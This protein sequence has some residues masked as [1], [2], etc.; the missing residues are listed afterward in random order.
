MKQSR[1][2]WPAI[3]ALLALPPLPAQTIDFARQVRPILSDKCYFCHGPAQQMKG[4]RFDR[5]ESAIRVVSKAA[6]ENE[7]L[8]RIT[9]QE[10]S[11]QMPPWRAVVSFTPAEVQILRTWVSL[12]AP[13]PEDTPPDPALE[14]LLRA[15]ARGDFASMKAEAR[16]RTV[17]NGHD[18]T[19]ATPLMHAAFEGN[20]ASMKLLL[21]AGADP[22]LANYTGSTALLW[23][24]D[25]LAKVRLLLAH[26]AK[27]DTRTSEGTTPLIAAA[28]F[29][30]CA[31]VLRALLD[32]GADPNAANRDGSTPLVQAA[33]IGDI[34]AMRFLIDRGARVNQEVTGQNPQVMGLSPLTVS[35][36]FGTTEMVQFLLERGAAVNAADGS[37]MTA[38]HIA[39]T[40]EDQKMIA[41]LIRAGAD[42]NRATLPSTPASDDPGT[43]LMLASNIE[44]ASASIVSTLLAYGARVDAVSR[45]GETAISRAQKRGQTAVVSALVAAGARPASGRRELATAPAGNPPTDVRAAVGKSLAL[46]RRA[47]QPFLQRAG[48][49]SC[50]NAALPALAIRMAAELGFSFDP[51]MARTNDAVTRSSI[52]SWFEKAVQMMDPDGGSP[53]STSFALINLDRPADTATNAIVRNIAARQLPDGRWRPP[54]IRHP[55]EEDATI[56]AISMRALQLYAPGGQRARYQMQIRKAA[57]WLS[58]FEPRTT[59]Q[60]TF[61]LLGLTWAKADAAQRRRRARELWTEQRPDGGWSQLNSLPSDAYATGEVL[62]AL[63]ESGMAGGHRFE[64]ERGVQFL[65]QTQ[66][67]D[68]SWHVVSRAVRF[69]QHFETGFPYGKDQFLSAAATSWAAMALMLSTR[70]RG[71]SGSH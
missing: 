9:S 41:A 53:T 30:G 3:S 31:P 2:F 66:Q 67:P 70:D 59:E 19:G 20:L 16:N 58:A 10:P 62:Y 60:R 37:G 44:P 65:M 4:L 71:G 8:H 25:D 48:C 32:A 23:A 28:M 39:V 5:R 33:S 15:I 45:E 26:G 40:R 55:M 63:A 47:N 43:P 21:E 1:I 49:Q 68:G 34:G 38:L 14:R 6:S 56:T 35:A 54:Y 57:Q 11:M 29:H 12:G 7:F 69:Q 42:V 27:P 64:Y 51:D 52:A 17:L 13:W 24:A 61:Q 18:S 46:L 36:Y 22:N 50:H